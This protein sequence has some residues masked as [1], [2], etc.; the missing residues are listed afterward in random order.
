MKARQNIQELK[1]KLRSYKRLKLIMQNRFLYSVPTP[2]IYWNQN[3]NSLILNRIG[4][5][6]F[7]VYIIHVHGLKINTTFLQRRVIHETP[8]WGF[9]AAK[10]TRVSVGQINIRVATGAKELLSN[11]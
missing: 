9:A 8:K 5:Y 7:R 11:Y 3:R 6:M 1:F 4:F 10:P 2:V